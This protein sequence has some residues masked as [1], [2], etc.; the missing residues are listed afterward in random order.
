MKSSPFSRYVRIAVLGMLVAAGFL[1]GFELLMMQVE[2]LLIGGPKT[3]TAG[4]Q[5]SPFLL[6]EPPP[7]SSQVNGQTVKINDTGGH[8]PAIHL[9]KPTATRRVLV[10]GDGVAFGEGVERE[11]TYTL[12]AIR[13]LGGERVG[14]EPIMMAVPGYS[15]IQ[16]RNLMAMR[17]WNL[18]PD[19]LILSGPGVELSVEPYVD[20]EVISAF[21]GTQ[22][23]RKTLETWAFSRV[24]DHIVR[25]VYSKTAARRKAVFSEGQNKNPEGRPRVGTNAYAAHL[26]A[27]VFDANDAGVDVVFVVLPLSADLSENIAT[28]PHIERA[29]LYRSVMTDAAERHGLP[30]VDGPAIFIESERE[31]DT[32]FLGERL[33]TVRGH[34]TLGYALAKTLRIWM[35]GRSINTQGT[36]TD[37]PRYKEPQLLPDGG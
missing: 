3:P 21:R 29:K 37:I 7:G 9:A 4:A 25:V 2:P 30:I 36:G 5:S 13:S 8:E 18:E 34:H 1:Y 22:P 19:L 28:H 33:M 11:Q 24:I 17:G 12:D 23:A 31:S 15:I 14:V 16:I 6:W 27:L 10:L 20:L 32:L 26:D 35:R